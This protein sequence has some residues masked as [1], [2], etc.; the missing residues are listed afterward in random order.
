[1]AWHHHSP[2]IGIRATNVSILSTLG[3]WHTSWVIS[4]TQF[5]QCLP[6][7]EVDHLHACCLFGCDSQWISLPFWN[8][9]LI[10]AKCHWCKFF[11]CTLLGTFPRSW[12]VQVILPSLLA[13]TSGPRGI[14]GRGRALSLPWIFPRRSPVLQRPREHL[15]CDT[16]LVPMVE[17]RPPWGG[18]PGEARNLQHDERVGWK[19]RNCAHALHS[20][21]G[22]KE[23]GWEAGGAQWEMWPCS[24]C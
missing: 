3:P 14:W 7:W 4:D 8:W 5:P 24:K 2:R 1:M 13:N 22:R 19:L 18:K 15:D 20:S 12:K 23:Q 16:R 9:N 21:Q 10:M 17:K 11:K 6:G